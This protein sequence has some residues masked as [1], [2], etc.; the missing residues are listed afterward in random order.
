MGK[1]LAVFAHLLILESIIQNLLRVLECFL[2][3]EIR[4]SRE[5]KNLRSSP[6][7][8]WRCFVCLA[9]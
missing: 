4:W 3:M 6:L 5:G 2:R 1:Q 7:L 9:L 8:S